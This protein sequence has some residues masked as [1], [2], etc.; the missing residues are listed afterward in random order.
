MTYLFSNSFAFRF[1]EIIL[2]TY[3]NVDILKYSNFVNVAYDHEHIRYIY[4][5]GYQNGVYKQEMHL[6]MSTVL[7][8]LVVRLCGVHDIHDSHT[9]ID[10]QHLT[11]AIPYLIVIRPQLVDRYKYNI[12]Q[13][14]KKG[15]HSHRDAAK[16][17]RRIL[18]KHGRALLWRRTTRRDSGRCISCYKYRMA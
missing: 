4:M 14:Y 2:S 10:K 5:S 16:I 18:K 3:N 1:L 9:E 17:L 8:N 6:Q 12:R 15:I 13:C 7:A 11:N